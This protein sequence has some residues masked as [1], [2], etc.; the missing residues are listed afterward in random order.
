M[1]SGNKPA[2]LSIND[3]A[4][5]VAALNGIEGQRLTH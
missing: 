2:N 5:T 1:T 3:G 4:R